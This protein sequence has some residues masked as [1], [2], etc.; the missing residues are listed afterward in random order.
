MFCITFTNANSINMS[1]VE[2]LNHLPEVR[3]YLITLI[4]ILNLLFSLPGFN[5]RRSLC[6]L[7]SG[8]SSAHSCDSSCFAWTDGWVSSPRDGET[9]AFWFP[10]RRHVLSPSFSLIFLSFAPSLAQCCSKARIGAT[11]WAFSVLLIR[12]HCIWNCP[13]KCRYIKW[14]HCQFI[15]RRLNII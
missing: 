7:I 15:C 5:R 11:T 13:C 14:L 1:E 6:A 2:H 10:R 4:S 9:R 8:P 12:H 3:C